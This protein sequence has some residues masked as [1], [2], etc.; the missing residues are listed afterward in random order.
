M[1][2]A[3]ITILSAVDTA[4]QN[5]AQQD[6]GQAVSASFTAV[7]GDTTANGTIKIQCANDNPAPQQRLSYSVPA[8]HWCDI[9]NATAAVTAGVAPAIVIPNMCFS[10]IRAVYTKSSGGSTTVVVYMNVLSM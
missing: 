3:Q 5:G 6:V 7:F 9:P 1:R 4:S 10:W 8:A 2:N